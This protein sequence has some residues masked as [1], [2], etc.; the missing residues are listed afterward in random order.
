[1]T[2]FRRWPPSWNAFEEVVHGC[3]WQPPTDIYETPEGLV[4]IAEVGGISHSDLT[5]R[6][7]DEIL[8]VRGTRQNYGPSSAFHRMEIS[9][10]EF[11]IRATLPE[12][13]K[14]EESDVV[15]KYENGFLVLTFPRR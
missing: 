6:I 9:Y 12:H 11:C 13:F 3:A 10:G 7:T 15:V 2:S 4:V 1:M 14:I 5:I 8:L